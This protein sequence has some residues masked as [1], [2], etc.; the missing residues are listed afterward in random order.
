MALAS[1]ALSQEGTVASY[2]LAAAIEDV[3][4]AG[5]RFVE[6]TDLELQAR[7]LAGRL[8]VRTLKTGH[9]AELLAGTRPAVKGKHRRTRLQLALL[10]GELYLDTKVY[11]KADPAL[12]RAVG[13]CRGDAVAHEHYQACMAVAACQQLRGIPRGAVSWLRLARRTASEYD[14][15]VRLADAAY[16]LGN[17]LAGQGDAAGAR[18]ALEQALAARLNPLNV[19]VALMVLSRLDFTSGAYAQGVDHAVKAAQAAA[20]IG[21]ASAFADGTILASQC[22]M[23]LGMEDDARATLRAGATA[24]RNQ[25]LDVVADLVDK[26][27][28]DT[29]REEP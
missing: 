23:G 9:A 27:Y 7:L 4:A 14:D 29:F 3:Q 15:D 20:A 10:E 13:L 5:R 18:K 8:L 21:N 16:A 26:H 11:E 2:E 19:P 22:Q 6:D 17:L 12:R 1:I 28:R 25:Q 24:L